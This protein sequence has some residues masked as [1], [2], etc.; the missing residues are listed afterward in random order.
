MTRELRRIYFSVQELADAIGSFRKVDSKFLPPGKICDIEVTDVHVAIK[1]EMK[2]VDNLH[3][4][5]FV[6]PYAKMTDILVTY[7]VERGVPLPRLSKRTVGL[8][9]D[10]VALEVVVGETA[11]PG[12]A[13]AAGAR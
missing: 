8:I 9:D 2:Y 7:C 10:E 11:A 1:I 3:V 6:I 4:L 12:V 13:A 5:D